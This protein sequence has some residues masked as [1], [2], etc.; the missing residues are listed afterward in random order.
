MLLALWARFVI[1]YSISKT[2]FQKLDLLPTA[3][4]MLGRQLL[5]CFGQEEQ[6][7]VSGYHVTA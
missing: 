1:Q 2:K 5:S 7:L 4:E 6:R 3:G